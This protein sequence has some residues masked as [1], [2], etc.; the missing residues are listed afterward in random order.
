M[1]KALIVLAG[2]I[3]WLGT[4][5]I[6]FAA[7]APNASGPEIDPA[8]GWFSATSAATNVVTAVGCVGAPSKPGSYQSGVNS[9]EDAPG[10]YV[11][12]WGT[13]SG[14]S[15]STSTKEDTAIDGAF[16]NNGDF[17]LD[18]TLAGPNTGTTV[19]TKNTANVV[20]GL[21]VASGTFTSYGNIATDP[22]HGSSSGTHK[23]KLTGAFNGVFKIVSLSAGPNNDQTEYAGRGLINAKGYQYKTSGANGAGYYP[24]GNGLV[25]NFEVDV[26]QAQ[27]GEQGS[28][29]GY[30]GDDPTG[31]AGAPNGF[32]YNSGNIAPVQPDLSVKTTVLPING[33]TAF[34]CHT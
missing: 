19:K 34:R 10:V 33:S 16:P 21:V 8:T 12:E 32:T 15:S 17:G 13:G 7:Y 5:S 29:Q 22:G 14:S 28:F 20:N 2:A 23:G 31:G 27:S 26:I 11:S 24:T 6:A 4:S 30:F 25:A 1:K 18:S 3:L 9:P